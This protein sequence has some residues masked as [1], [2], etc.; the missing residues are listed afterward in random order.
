MSN[1]LEC[2]IPNIFVGLCFQSL[3]CNTVLRAF[4]KFKMKS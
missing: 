4:F 2:F 3:L 1:L